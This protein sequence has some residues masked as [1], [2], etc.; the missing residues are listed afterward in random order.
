LPTFGKVNVVNIGTDWCI[1]LFCIKHIWFP[2]RHQTFSYCLPTVFAFALASPVSNFV[3]AV[4]LLNC[5]GN[6]SDAGTYRG[7][8]C[9]VFAGDPGNNRPCYGASHS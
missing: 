3:A 9:G 2:T 8:F 5:P 4:V 7:A 6:S 1:L